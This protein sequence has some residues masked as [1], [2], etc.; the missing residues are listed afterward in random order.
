MEFQELIEKRRSVRSY[1]GNKKV[2]KELMTQMVQAAIEA[3]SWKNS[4]TARYYVVMDEQ[5]LRKFESEC[6]PT[7]NQK[8]SAG[9]ALI[10]ATFK[11]GRAGFD[12]VT[13]NPDNEAGNGR[14]YYDMGLSN[15][16]FV[17]KA[18]ELGLDTLIMGIRD[19]DKIKALLGIPE[20]ELVGP[21][22]AVG[23][24][25]AVSQRPKRKMP[26]EIIKFC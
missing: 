11:A 25:N 16:N 18:K 12:R 7:F 2:N 10:V 8:N 6:L 17:L 21:V 14:G 19:A 13:G 3:P 26:E 22:I 1:D 4:Q 15:A 20:D 23:Y 5:I 24:G 9:A